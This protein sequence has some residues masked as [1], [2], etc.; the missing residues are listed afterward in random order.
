MMLGCCYDV[1]T[2]T[3]SSCLTPRPQASGL[4]IAMRRLFLLARWLPH[5]NVSDWLTQSARISICQSVKHGRPQ[6]SH[7]N[8]LRLQCT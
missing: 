4:R 2:V 7:P 3:V 5:Q 8:L 1:D 6:T